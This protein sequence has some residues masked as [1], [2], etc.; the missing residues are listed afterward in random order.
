VTYGPGRIFEGLFLVSTVQRPPLLHGLEHGGHSLPHQ[1]GAM[2]FL[3]VVLLSEPFQFALHAPDLVYSGSRLGCARPRRGECPPN[4]A[5]EG[6]RESVFSAC[7]LDPCRLVRQGSS[8]VGSRAKFA[9]L[10]Q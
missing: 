2:A 4:P 7:R 9:I 8:S 5:C 1:I 6:S 10:P 3:F